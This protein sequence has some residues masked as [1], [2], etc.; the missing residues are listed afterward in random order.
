MQIQGLILNDYLLLYLSRDF[1][2]IDPKFPHTEYVT[3]IRQHNI[4]Y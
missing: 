3:N 1:T 4:A 2:N